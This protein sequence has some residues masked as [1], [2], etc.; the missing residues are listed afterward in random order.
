[1]RGG[2]R[3][4]LIALRRCV[5]F[6]SFAALLIFFASCAGHDTTGANTSA[7]G[8]QPL[9]DDP[10]LDDKADGGSDG[11]GSAL[12]C[13]TVPVL[14]QL[15]NA[16][17]TLSIDGQTAH[18]TGDGYDKVFP[19][20]NGTIITDMTDPN[21]G[22]SNSYP[23]IAGGK[24]DFAITP[25]SIQECKTWWT[26]PD[27]GAQSPVFAGLPF[28]SWDGDY[29]MHGPVDN[30]TAPNGGTLRRGYVSHGCFRMEAADILEVYGR[31]KG[32]ASVPVHVQREA[33]R[34]ADGTR[35]D[36]PNV[37]VG[38][39]C[40]ADADC[41]YAGGYCAQNAYAQHGFCSA[42]C[43]QYCDDR[44]DLPTTFCV[45]DP[46]NA[47]EGMCVPKAIDT[48][49]ECRPYDAMKLAAATPRYNQPSVT[50]DVCV[51]GSPGWVGDHCFADSDCGNGTTCLGASGTAPGICSETCTKYCPDEVGF[52]DTFCAEAPALANGGTCLRQCTPSDNGAECP[53]DMT[54]TDE[55][56]LGE[57]G[58]TKYV[59]M[60]K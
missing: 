33:E 60:P 26:D 17:I 51:P 23:P 37:W 14:P 39:A 24:H 20:G 19:V 59:C 46:S 12:D 5:R 29:A 35:V 18:L 34:R 45:A 30:Y 47:N 36:V 44:A 9:G 8:D 54:C 48:N 15:V 1:L 52:A 6:Y 50:A 38:A 31:I 13:K 7:G 2:A 42:H 11:W 57:P 55:P 27:T 58:T 4:S 22:E 49:Y 56:R 32:I 53:V 16:H 10:I 28:L 21:Y 25:S 41:T 40:T 3:G 43:T